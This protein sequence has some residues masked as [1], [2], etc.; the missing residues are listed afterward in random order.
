LASSKHDG[1]IDSLIDRRLCSIACLRLK[2]RFPLTAHILHELDAI[3][4]AVCLGAEVCPLFVILPLPPL[5]THLTS[6]GA[7]FASIRVE[8]RPHPSPEPKCGD[9]ESMP[10]PQLVYYDESSGTRIRHVLGCMN[11]VVGYVLGWEIGKSKTL[12]LQ[13][14]ASGP[15]ARSGRFASQWLRCTRSSILDLS[16]TVKICRFL[17]S[18]STAQMNTL[19]QFAG[20]QVGCPGKERLARLAAS[21]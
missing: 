20:S 14:P 18:G 4:R 7:P 15:G 10:H 8:S 12:Y 9:N 1:L 19:R 2:H 13:G 16:M 17:V 6:I 11:R 21:G 3:G 5:R